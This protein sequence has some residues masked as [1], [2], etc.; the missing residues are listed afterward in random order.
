MTQDVLE[1]IRSLRSKQAE[2]RWIAALRLGDTGDLR[3]LVPLQ[4]A[5]NDR[6]RFVRMNASWSL[7]RLGP[8]ALPILLQAFRAKNINIRGLIPFALAE[9]G[10]WSTLDILIAALED[11]VPVVRSQVVMALP[12]FPCEQTLAALT[13]A[14]VDPDRNVR[15]FAAHSLRQLCE[16]AEAERLF[17][18]ADYQ[19]D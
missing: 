17:A 5:L 9:L 19:E 3:A 4:Q 16:P 7:A 18:A 10:D 6:N 8:A 15:Y 14:L 1:L 2:V 12:R 13:A 11:P